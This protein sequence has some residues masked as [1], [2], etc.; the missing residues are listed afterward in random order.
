MST[1]KTTPDTAGNGAKVAPLVD[2]FKRPL[3]DLRI[4]VTDRCNFRC[5]YCM[6]KEVFGRDYEFLARGEILTFEEIARL[7]RVFVAH[8]VEKIR[9]TGGEPTVRRDLPRLIEML[10]AI[11]GLRD[12]TLT[13]NGSLIAGMARSLKEAGLSRV[14]VSLDSLDDAVFRSMNDVEFP[15]SQV[16][17]G[18]EAAR[19][20]GLAPVKVNMVVKRGI[21]DHTVVDM[22]RHFRGTGSIVRFIEYMDV[23]TTNGWRL[24]DVVPAAEIV[25]QIGREFPLEPVAPTYTGEVANRYRYL[26]GAGEIGV[27]SS[28]TAPFCGDC[29][30]ARLSADG[31]LYTC[32]FGV[33]GHDFRALLRNGA[34]DA[35]I[36]VRVRGVWSARKDQYSELRAKATPDLPK[37]E[38]SYIGG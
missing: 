12:L 35:E 37:V 28:V 3:H 22:A 16:L 33:K 38:M 36:E 5:T 32:L 20:E 26:D 9:L 24:D 14:T 18:I 31:K 23:G 13:T 34:S 1:E 4:S 30:R 7:A 27:I 6:P 29:T 8:G 2:A 10:A 19:R 15:V 11:E 17:D 21:N 25:A